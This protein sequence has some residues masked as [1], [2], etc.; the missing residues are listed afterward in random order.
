M[1]RHISILIIAFGLICATQSF[2]QPVDVPKTN[3]Q[4]LYMHYMPWFETPH[5]LGGNNWG[6]HWKMNNQNPNIITPDVNY[7]NGEKRQIASHYYP[8]IGPYDSSDPD[9][10]EYHLLLMKYSG[11]DG[12]LIDWYG[13][14]GTNGDIGTLLTSSNDLIDQTDDFGMDFAVVLEDRFSAN[15]NQAKANVAYLRD[16]YFNNPQYIRQ[17]AGNDPLLM[18]FGPIT[19]QSPSQWTTILGE[20]G[21]DV[22]FLP[23][24]FEEGDAGSNADGEYSWVW[25]DESQDDYL[26][27]LANFYQSRVPFL[28]GQGKDLAGGSAFP[29]FDDFYFEGGLGNV[30]PFD[31][32]H[33]NGQTLASTLNLAGQHAGAVDF[34]QL[35]TWNDF[36]EG[37]IFEPTVETGYDYLVQLQQYSGSPYTQSELE[38][39]HDLYLARKEYAGDAGTQAA[40]DGVASLLAGLDIIGARAA[41]LQITD[42][43]LVGD[44]DGDGFVGIADLNIVLGA[45]NQA[46]TPGDLSAGD[47]SGDGFVGI[48]DLNVLLGNWNAFTLPTIAVPEPATLGLLGLLG[49]VA[50]LGRQRS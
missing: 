20:A 19:F 26:A 24:W 37:T 4:K 7:P 23:L 5:T 44:L 30:V 11:V 41:L 33:D 42:P 43:I 35:V 12:V 13:V 47:P 46:V 45:W 16:N 39:V 28:N 25:E 50:V 40:L 18:S 2:G 34:M 29:G 10:I 36:G 1:P 6:W 17:G 48:L 32:P 49:G 27:R 31:I 21:E 8:Q 14:Q 3:P 22:D 15:I 9:V 38:L